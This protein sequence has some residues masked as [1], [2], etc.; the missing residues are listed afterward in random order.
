MRSHLPPMNRVKVALCFMALALAAIP[1]MASSWVGLYGGGPGLTFPSVI[2]ATS[3][4][5]FIVAAYTETFGHGSE[6]RPDILLLKLD[7]QGRIKWQKVIGTPGHTDEARSII[8]ASDGRIVLAGLTYAPYAAAWVVALAPTGEI[9]WQRAYGPPSYGCYAQSIAECP[10]GGF[11][12]C[13]TWW[14]HEV[15]QEHPWVL[16]MDSKG[17][18]LWQRA[19]GKSDDYWNVHG[20]WLSVFPD[21]DGGYFVWGWYSRYLSD[22]GGAHLAKLD[23]SGNILWQRL[24]NGGGA[25]QCI[26]TQDGGFAIAGN[27]S[28]IARITKLDAQGNVLWNTVNAADLPYATGLLGILPNPNGG[29]TVL[30]NRH[31]EEERVF[32]VWLAGVSE[33][34][35]VE[36]ENI[37]D[38]ARSAGGPDTFCSSPGGGVAL[39]ISSGI[40]A[41]WPD[42]RGYNIGVLRTEADFSI[43]D[44]CVSV[45]PVQTGWVSAPVTV[46]DGVIDLE[47]I[48]LEPGCEKTAVVPQTTAVNEAHSFCPVIAKARILHNPFRLELTGDCFFDWLN[49]DGP[50]WWVAIDGV[51]VPEIKPISV[52]KMILKGGKELKA[53]LPKG[54][55]AC[56]QIITLSPYEPLYNSACYTLTR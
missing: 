31:D 17:K 47:P 38:G 2:A 36:W 29:Y 20:G 45:T 3:N 4:G 33:D 11:I 35:A 28:N 43:A 55:P 26:R 12:L 39:A 16:R 42:G 14:D 50:S 37:Y 1:G 15:G 19:F 51:R 22:I 5:R 24:Y 21:T 6:E 13:G 7:D 10:D 32:G 53:M 25:R 46:L 18:V 9:S 48:E 8:E 40:D 27:W 54:Q 41:T 30:G 49:L 52:K 34:G 56:I 44:P 23:S